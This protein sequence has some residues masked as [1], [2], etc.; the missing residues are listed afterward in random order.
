MRKAGTRIPI[1]LRGLLQAGLV[2]WLMLAMAHAT[3]AQQ[4]EGV[5]T[6]LA[7]P[8][9]EARAEALMREI[10]CLVCQGQSIAESHADL[11]R[12]LR[13]LVRE[14]VAAGMS[15]ADIRALLKARYG[16]WIL[17]RPP[18]ERKTW[19]LWFGPPLL[20]LALIV[21]LVLRW[22]HRRPRTN[23]DETAGLASWVA[24]AESDDGERPA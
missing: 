16:D 13:M 17:L 1:A 2:A 5:E 22:R 3:C 18:V 20:L 9:A 10:R 19:P 6:P 24:P 11:A 14:K 15:D 4:A 7:D 21:L 23:E 12:D 8:A